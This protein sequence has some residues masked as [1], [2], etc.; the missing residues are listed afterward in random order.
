MGAGFDDVDAAAFL[1]GFGMTARSRSM[2]FEAFARSFFCN[3]GQLSAA[4]LIA[5]FHYYFLGNPEGIGFDVPSTDYATAIWDPLHRHLDRHGA[6][7]QMSTGC[8]SVEPNGHGW[9]VTTTAG[10]IDTR[11]VVMAL[12]P[13]LMT[14]WS[15]VAGAGEYAKRDFG[16]RLHRPSARGSA[17]AATPQRVTASLTFRPDPAVRTGRGE[18]VRNTDGEQV[19]ALVEGVRVS[20]GGEFERIDAKSDRATLTGGTPYERLNVMVGRLNRSM[21]RNPLLTE[22]MTRAF[23]FADASAT[24]EVDQVASIIDRL[25]AG[26][27]V[28]E[29]EPS[30][31]ELAKMSRE[32]LL[33]LGGKLDGVEI[34]YKEPR[35]PVPGTKAEKRAERAVAYW[36][37]LGGISGLALLLVFLFWPWEYV[38]FGGEGE[39]LWY[40]Y[41]AGGCGAF[42]CAQEASSSCT[43]GALAVS[44]MT[45]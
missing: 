16:T 43:G 3:Q 39:F 45:P 44:E 23:M 12:D 34:V 32:E 33:E 36:L 9:R 30:D 24:A 10:T 14:G 8:V 6:D 25:F 28:D 40:S 35:W 13:T 26:A 11:H 38:P 7:V 29:G 2:L 22:A 27:I 41:Q 4:E 5:M 1:D 42:A 19:A 31:E 18:G 37:L 21:Q 17:L 15:G 20:L